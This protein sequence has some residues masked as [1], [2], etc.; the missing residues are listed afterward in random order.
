MCKKAGDGFV[1]HAVKR[2]GDPVA[3]VHMICGEEPFLLTQDLNQ[4]GVAF[5][6]DDVDRS[7]VIQSQLRFRYVHQKGEPFVVSAVTEYPM[8]WVL[9]PGVLGIDAELL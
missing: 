7:F 2:H 1:I 6:V 9:G 4:V 5:Q 3:L 8:A